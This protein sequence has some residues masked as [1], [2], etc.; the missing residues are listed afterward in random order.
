V[1]TV[2]RFGQI[3]VNLHVTGSG[4]LSWYGH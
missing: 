4:R 1:F 2:C 3:G